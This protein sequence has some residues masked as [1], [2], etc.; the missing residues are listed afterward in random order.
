[1]DCCS[2]ARKTANTVS[3]DTAVLAWNCFYRLIK[4]AMT[5]LRRSRISQANQVAPTHCG[6]K[7]CRSPSGK[8]RGFFAKMAAMNRKFAKIAGFFGFEGARQP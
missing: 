8:A 1:M 2:Y 6:I 4:A 3:R 7:P 5:D